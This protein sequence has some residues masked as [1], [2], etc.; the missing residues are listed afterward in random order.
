MRIISLV[1]SW[2]ETL[3]AAGVPV[4]GRTR[5]CIHPKDQVAT[6][7]IVGGTKSVNWQQIHSLQP[8]LLILDRQENPL[9]F[10]QN[11]IPYWASDVRDGKSLAEGLEL[12]AK[13]L[14]NAQLQ[15]WSD[16]ARDISVAP[17]LQTPKAHFPGCEKVLIPWDTVQS[18]RFRY[19][20]WKSPWMEVTR[21]TYLGFTLAQMGLQIPESKGR[22]LYPE[23]LIPSEN[24]QDVFLFSSEPYPFQ[25]DYELLQKLGVPGAIVDGEKFSW[26]GIRSLRFL[27]KAL[28][29]PSPEEFFE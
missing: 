23:L 4:I 11:S 18:P 1:P 19:V 29:I 5:Y 3:L 26:F 16:W 12:L 8:D 14:G 25:R 22:G 20:I 10:S 28:Q 7:P 24:N 9:S 2:T 15:S 6:I 27:G 21:E 17:A 13:H